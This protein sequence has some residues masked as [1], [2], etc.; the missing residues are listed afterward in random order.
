MAPAPKSGRPLRL[1]LIGAGAW[2]ERAHLRALADYDDAEVVALVDADALRAR[3]VASSH[4]IGQV[5]SDS[6]ALFD[7]VPDL[8]AVLIATPTDTHAAIAG[9]ALEAGVAILCEKPLAYD[10]AQARVIAEAARERGVVTKLGFIFRFSPVI[11]RMKQLIEEG[12][13]GTV[14]LFESIN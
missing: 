1:A 5:F 11:A 13:I 12:S 7:A 10:L 4:A 6:G 14:Q 9:R 2:G 3:E 8:D